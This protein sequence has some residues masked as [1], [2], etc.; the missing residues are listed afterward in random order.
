ME[1]CGRCNEWNIRD[2]GQEISESRLCFIDRVTYPAEAHFLRNKMASSG[3]KSTMMKFLQDT[4]KKSHPATKVVSFFFHA[5][6][7]MLQKSIEGMYRSLLYDILQIF[8]ELQF[9]L[10]DTSIIASVHQGCPDRDA[11][12]EL[13]RY[14][15]QNLGWRW[16]WKITAIRAPEI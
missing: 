5:R 11:L 2:S 13:L 10:D 1:C 4:A 14:A 6:G 3:G 12:K 8:P 9:I 15:V 16:M 7:D